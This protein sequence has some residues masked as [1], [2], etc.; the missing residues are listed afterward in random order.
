MASAAMFTP[1]IVMCPPMRYTTS[2]PSVKRM[3]LRSSATANRFL[4][5]ST[6]MADSILQGFGSPAGGGDLLG[7]FPAELVRANREAFADVAAGQHFHPF[8][9]AGHQ[10]HFAE[11][12][13]GD[14]GTLVETL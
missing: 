10:A 5:L 14:H 6:A 1:G 12:L 4:M 11:Q 13:G 9:R 3:R 2:R 7:G 8:R